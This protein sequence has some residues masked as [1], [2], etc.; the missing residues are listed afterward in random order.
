MC[1]NRFERDRSV[2]EQQYKTDHWLEN[3]G[4][5]LAELG[6]AALQKLKEKGGK[7]NTLFKAELFSFILQNAQLELRTEDLFVDKINHGNIL[8]NIRNE[9][10]YEAERDHLMKAF[11]AYETPGSLK[12]YRAAVANHTPLTVEKVTNGHRATDA[13]RN[14]EEQAQATAGR[15]FNGN[16]DFSHAAPGWEDIMCLGITGLLKRLRTARDMAENLTEEQREFYSAGETVYQAVITLMKRYSAAAKELYEATGSERMRLVSETCA[17]LAVRAPQSLHEAMQLSVTYYTLLVFLEGV[18][19]RTLGYIDRLFVP[20]YR[21]DISSGRLTKE[22]TVEMLQHYFIKFN[23]MS[24]LANT[25]F[26]LCGV[27]RHGQSAYNELSELILD[28]Y[29]ALDIHDPKIQIRCEPGIPGSFLKNALALIRKGSSSIV[30]MNDEVIIRGLCALGEDIEDARRFIPIGCYEPAAM[31]EEV[32]C[33][34]SGR[35]NIPKALELVINRGVDMLNGDALSADH[36]EPE[37]FEEFYAALCGVLRE[38][39]DRSVA[40]ISAF[41]KHYAELNPSPLFSATFSSCVKKGRDAYVGGAKYNNT[42]INAF[43]LAETVDAL[44]AVKKA[45]YEEKVLALPELREILCSDWAGNEPLR[46]KIKNLYPKYGNGI[47]EADALA[48]RLVDDVAGMLNGRPNARG[49][50][51]RCGFFSID[52][53][54]FFGNITA[55]LPNGRKAGEMLSKNMCAVIGA[56]KKGITTLINS[57]TKID[58]SKIPNG[59]VLDVVLH[60]SAV[61]GE[62]G[63]DAML[64]VLRTY[65]DAGGHSIHF[66][67]LD[68]AILRKAQEEPEQYRNLQIRLCGWN[69]HFVN[70]NRKE[71]DSFIRSAE[72]AAGY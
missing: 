5:P 22:Q 12:N 57:S 13:D 24:V 15:G 69:V 63:L 32:P 52:A 25:P 17:A 36:G 42:S 35:I 31:G 48:R 46:M 51:Y 21:K 26:T 10:I 19:I 61:R 53:C 40:L 33:T 20:F 8:C 60:E 68:P 72:H 66:N 7:S 38:F 39:T 45:V 29:G 1:W 54:E 41:E 64:A 59:T 4:L 67:V 47:A 44:L 14:A 27:D 18:G 28:V 11:E 9:W 49:G 62:D 43:G 71:Q 50:V 2:L 56:D 58:Y 16:P 3:S 23:A 37:S 65:L 34:C 6:A 30:F 70:L 55:A